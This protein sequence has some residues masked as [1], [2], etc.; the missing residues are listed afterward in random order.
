MEL[1][2]NVP[3]NSTLMSDIVLQFRTQFNL[4]LIL[5]TGFPDTI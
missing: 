1:Q 3:N 2:A 4:R 5:Q